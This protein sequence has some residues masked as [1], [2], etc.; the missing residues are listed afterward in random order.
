[1][2][3]GLYPHEHG[4]TENDGRFGGRAGLTRDDWTFNRAFERAGYSCAWFG[5]W[6]VNNQLTARDFGFAGFAPAGYGYPYGTPEYRDYLARYGLEAPIAQ[7]TIP[8]E[9]HLKIGTRVSLLESGDWFD[10]VSGALTLEGSVLAHESHFVVDEAR[11]WFAATSGPK[12]VRVDPWGPHPPYLLGGAYTELDALSS[13]RLPENF[14]SDL[15]HRPQHHRRY[16]DEWRD[17]LGMEPDMWLRMRRAALAQALLIEAAVDQW[18]EQLDPERTVVVFTCDHGDAVAS[19]GGVANKGSLMVEATMSIPLLMMGPGI[20]AH[21]SSDALASNMDIVPTLLAHVGVS[22][23][24][25]FHGKDLSPV[26]RG[27]C[28]QVRQGFM[29]QHFG[30]HEP[31]SQRAWYEESWKLVMQPDGQSELYN[32]ST[33]GQELSNL[34]GSLEHRSR[35]LTLRKNLENAMREVNDT[36]SW[37]SEHATTS[38]S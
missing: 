2:L 12:L 10:D 36:P 28:T 7:V 21:Q 31:I 9:S 5:K 16:R 22:H 1:M 18:V 33:D 24:R 29:A 32:L 17:A 23:D 26:L 15:S 6:H 27:E 19:N 37:P 30:L 4:V 3:T 35:L 25:S 14:H 20:R 8:G 11:R 13:V 34:A 38:L